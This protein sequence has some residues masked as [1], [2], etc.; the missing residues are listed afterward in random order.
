MN[1]WDVNKDLTT[2]K[3]IGHFSEWA[4]LTEGAADEALNIVDDSPFSYGRFWP[5]IARWFGV[6]AGRPEADESKYQ[7]ITMPR[8]PAPRGFGPAG[9]VYI[10]WS[11]MEWAKRPEVKEVWE[12]IQERE[13]LRKDLD[14]WRSW[15][16]VQE[17]WGT[18]DAEILGGWGRAQT[19]DKAKKLG[20][21]GHVQTNEGIRDTVEKMVTMKMVPKLSA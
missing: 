14:P 16:K 10:T 11:F 17:V 5:E 4:V 3:I 9:K 1:A 21:Q 12:R 7:T 13:G 8:N 20:W 2:A 6:E 18:L 15:E 19:M